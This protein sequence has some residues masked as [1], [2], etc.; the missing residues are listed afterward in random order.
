VE[1]SG[2]SFSVE[3]Q[4]QGDGSWN[5]LV[6]DDLYDTGASLGAACQVLR[7][8]QKVR[9]IYVAAVIPL[10][11]KDGLTDCARSESAGACAPGPMGKPDAESGTPAYA[12]RPDLPACA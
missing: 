4:T 6:V 11:S 5:V 2:N 3:D 12:L 9:P 10:I 8:D 1:A 7:K